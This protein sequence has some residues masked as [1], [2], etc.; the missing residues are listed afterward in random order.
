MSEEDNNKNLSWKLFSGK[1]SRKEAA[2]ALLFS[3]FFSGSFKGMQASADAGE[4]R[5][6]RR[7]I[8]QPVAT[9]DE[10]ERVARLKRLR[11]PNETW[12]TGQK[13]RAAFDHFDKD[14]SG[15]IE[16]KD[17][18]KALRRLGLKPDKFEDLEFSDRRTGKVVDYQDLLLDFETFTEI[19]ASNS[20]PGLMFFDK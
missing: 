7:K 16:G 8:R 9:V 13:R 2:G 12:Q 11:S 5:Q 19:I 15:L 17:L 20:A 4:I 6:D 18:T 10:R 1:I 14:Q 3:G